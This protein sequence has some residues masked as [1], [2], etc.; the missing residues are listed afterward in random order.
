MVMKRFDLFK[1][2]QF[3]I[4]AMMVVACYVMALLTIQYKRTIIPEAIPKLM[5]VDKKTQQLASIITTGIH[6]NSFPAFSVNQN[7]FSIDAIIW[8]KFTKATESI[9]TLNK[10]TLK[11]SRLLG[12]GSLIY[13]SQP[14]IKVMNDDVLVCY[15]IQANF[16]ANLNYKKFPLEDHR[17]NII[18]E[19][20]S[21]NA[22]EMAFITEAQNVTLSDDILIDHWLPTKVHANAGYTI[23]EIMKDEEGMSIAYPC[24]VFTIDFESIGARLPISLYLPLFI[25]FFII[26]ISLTLKLDDTNRIGLVAAGVP[27]L[28]LFRLVIDAT[29]PQ[30]GYS[31]HI[32]QVYYFIV[33]LAVLIL[34]LQTYIA[35]AIQ[36]AEHLNTDS[37]QTI[38]HKLLKINATVFIIVLTSLVIFVTT[39]F[40]L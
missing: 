32:D 19:N 22:Q 23:S 29:A 34:L 16:M 40:I 3:Q 27:A 7:D 30:V 2:I 37:K 5:Q 4:I 13:K 36:K 10:F 8:F 14:I 9:E 21:V 24:A 28:V 33:S 17:L 12:D 35:L 31:T 1:S 11:N 18:L 6:I 20:K 15:H 39:I 26:L 25:L 38:E